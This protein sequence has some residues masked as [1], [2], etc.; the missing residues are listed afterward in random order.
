MSA[1]IRLLVLCLLLVSALNAPAF[2]QDEQPAPVHY[3]YKGDIPSELRNPAGI[4]AFNDVMFPSRANTQ[5][6]GENLATTI[7][8]PGYIGDVDS[9]GGMAFA[10]SDK[11]TYCQSAASFTRAD[12]QEAR[13]RIRELTD[14]LELESAQ[15]VFDA[16]IAMVPCI[17]D[18]VPKNV[19][20]DILLAMGVAY[21]FE[22]N[23][24]MARTFFRNALI[25]DAAHLEDTKWLEMYKPEVQTQY[26]RATKELA[27]NQRE[28]AQY[29]GA[30]HVYGTFNELKIN[31]KAA[32]D[33][34][35]VSTGLHVV[36]FVDA[37]GMPR[38]RLVEI[39]ESVHPTLLLFDQET[40]FNTMLG[41]LS[42]DSSELILYAT[43]AHLETLGWENLGLVEMQE[44][45][46]TRYIRTNED[47]TP[48]VI[49]G[50]SEVLPELMVEAKQDNEPRY[51]KG[52]R[53]TIRVIASA[54]GQVAFNAGGSAKIHG[55][56]SYA[57]VN[58]GLDLH[59]IG[60]LGV[61]VRGNL[62]FTTVTFQDG[63][64]SPGDLV[65]FG[66]G[67]WYKFWTPVVLRP[68][69]Q[70]EL[71]LDV[72]SYNLSQPAV[73]PAFL[74]GGGT[75]VVLP[76]DRFRIRLLILGGIGDEGEHVRF[77]ATGVVGLAIEL[78]KPLGPSG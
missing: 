18:G 55:P 32:S 70:I 78:R 24:V 76:D 54:P 72:D 29:Q 59:L 64:T 65:S 10:G 48:E 26:N 57:G 36:E 16:T 2:A 58:L 47:W 66:V 40:W 9:H 3:V 49:Q 60:G 53:K 43:W 74:A 56:A 50:L 33:V 1:V 63:T 62:G 68:F 45:D 75:E 5:V 67:A 7:A 11:V 69:I 30:L 19:L 23:N 42:R 51:V 4:A 6:L 31:G 13:G 73:R 22:S 39:G 17:S 12:L 28:G 27:D 38:T 15:D 37:S 8:F 14:L 77:R 41:D 46:G 61:G 20:A 34:T 21:I 25:I 35:N 71:G 52:E 44:R